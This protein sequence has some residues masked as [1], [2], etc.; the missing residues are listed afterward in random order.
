[1]DFLHGIMNLI[2]VNGINA[3]AIRRLTEEY[4]SYTNRFYEGRF[5]LNETITVTEQQLRKTVEF[6]VSHG[7]IELRYWNHKFFQNCRIFGL[8]KNGYFEGQ[9]S[10]RVRRVELWR[11]GISRISEKLFI[12]EVDRFRRAFL[13]DDPIVH[14][15]IRA[16]I[17]QTMHKSICGR[18]LNEKTVGHACLMEG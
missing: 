5:E 8:C 9:T 6:D 3:K 18:C 1:M 17:L 7:R 2:P 13:T 11:D 10:L 12:E 15:Q 4:K 14:D 16:A